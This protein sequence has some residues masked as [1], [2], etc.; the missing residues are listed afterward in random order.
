MFFKIKCKMKM[1]NWLILKLYYDSSIGFLKTN[2]KININ[3]I[4]INR[5]VKQGGILSPFLF[6][7]FIDQLLT[8]VKNEGIS[9]KWATTSQSWHIVMT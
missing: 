8:L 4:P 6:N 2:G 3:A 9:P 7:A 5:G 1:C